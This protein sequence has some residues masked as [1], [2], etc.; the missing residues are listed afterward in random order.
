MNDFVE[1]YRIAV[2]KK[3]ERVKVVSEGSKALDI[4]DEKK[5]EELLI[6]SSREIDDKY[7]KKWADQCIK[8]PES[9]I[10]KH[11]LRDRIAKE[12]LPYIVHMDGRGRIMT[13]YSMNSGTKCLTFT[14][15]MNEDYKTASFRC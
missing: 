12:M 6:N 2:H 1:K 7:I 4:N 13:N 14:F 11:K 10:E 15:K 5:T 9:F 3:D 8:N